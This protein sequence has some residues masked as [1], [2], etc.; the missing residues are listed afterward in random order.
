MMG[1]PIIDICVITKNLLPD[2][3]EDVYQKLE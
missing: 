1:K 3:P 2:I